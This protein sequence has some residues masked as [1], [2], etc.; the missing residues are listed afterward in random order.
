MAS[1]ASNMEDD[2]RPRIS[3][4]RRWEPCGSGETASISKTEAEQ[5]HNDIIHCIPDDWQGRIEFLTSFVENHSVSAEVLTA[6]PNDAK[7]ST[8]CGVSR[9]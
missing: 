6:D 9:K 1:V 3:H 5:F 4:W 7:L 2:W 8:S